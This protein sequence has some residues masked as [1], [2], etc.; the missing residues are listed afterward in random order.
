[1]I[2]GAHV[3][4]YSRDA[5]ADRAFLRDVLGFASVDAGEGWLIFALPPAEAAVHPTDGAEGCE[6]YLMCDDIESTVR[7]LSD[8]GAE[9][10]GPVAARGW[11]LLTGVRLPG[12]GQIGL[13]QP[14][15]PRAHGS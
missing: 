15:H 12:G 6:L 10:T 8:R 7:E 1:M 3:I 5:D 14:R 2:D 4:L 9:L 13:Y 11:G